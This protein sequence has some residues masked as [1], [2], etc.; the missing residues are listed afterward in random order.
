M[1]KIILNYNNYCNN[2]NNLPLKSNLYNW[3]CLIFY[4]Y[5][6]K[7]IINISIVEKI[8][9]QKLNMKFLNNNK[10]TNVL[11]FP[12]E[13]YLF[14]K[15]FLG[16]IILCKEIIEYEACIYNKKIEEYWAHMVIH[17]SLH[18]L[19]FD[20]FNKNKRKIMEIEEIKLLTILGYSNPYK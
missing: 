10:E 1:K 18:L 17:S 8:I 3:L 15:F 9:I 7:F 16:D 2:K 4:N 11:C 20:H 6:K 14:K 12:Y 19:K 5:K 13:D